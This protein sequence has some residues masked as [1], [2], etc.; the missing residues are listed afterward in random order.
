M[1]NPFSTIALVL[2]A[3]LFTLPAHAARYAIASNAAPVTNTPVMRGIFGGK[4]GRTLKTDHCGQVRELEFIAL[5]GTLFKV[6]GEQRQGAEVVYRIEMDGYPMPPGSELYVDG[7]FME[8]HDERLRQSAAIPGRE[9]VISALKQSVGS[10]YVWGGN[11]RQGIR[12]LLGAYYS[13][14]FSPT[15]EKRLTLAGLDCSGLLY[16][17][18]DGYT[19]RN[20]SWLVEFGE[21]MPVAGKGVAE[22]AAMLEPLDLIVWKG[23]VIIVLDR[24][25]VIESRLECN[26]PGHGGVVTTPLL[27]RLAEV[28]KT[29]SPLD[30]WP[31]GNERQNAFVVRRWHVMGKKN[32]DRGVAGSRKSDRQ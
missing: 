11:V 5:P 20:T 21:G 28:M 2:A 6:V 8:L 10:H 15:E 4:D 22:I 32:T 31:Q 29:R 30:A 7:R 23:H 16:A 24:N 26:T 27:Q 18:T 17:A 3:I 25:T 13:G 12:E 19:P 14:V 1:N 9:S